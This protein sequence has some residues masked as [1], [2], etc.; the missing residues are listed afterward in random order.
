MWPFWKWFNWKPIDFCP[1]SQIPC[2]WNPN[3]NS[4][5]NWS[6][7]QETIPPTD[8]QKEGRTGGKNES[9]ILPTNFVGRGY[10]CTR[11]ISHQIYT[12]LCCAL[13]CFGS[14]LTYQL[15]LSFRAVSLA[16]G[17]SYDCPSANE[18][19]LKDMG[20]I[21]QYLSTTKHNNAETLCIFV[22]K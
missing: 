8:G 3:W 14:L 9:N 16:L 7:A 18:A 20:K 21:S 4:T 13:L 2:T 10:E 1:Q 11:S 12:W 19:I 6:Y 15:P 17:Q 22:G 5:A